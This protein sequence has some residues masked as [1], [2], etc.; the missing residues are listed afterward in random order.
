MK[1]FLFFVIGLLTL[2]W[3]FDGKYAQAEQPN[4]DCA[5]LPSVVFKTE[6]Q[7]LPIELAE[8]C[9]L[10][11]DAFAHSYLQSLYLAH[12]TNVSESNRTTLMRPDGNHSPESY[13]KALLIRMLTTDSRPAYS[14]HFY[15]QEYLR[16]AVEGDV[17]YAK[18]LAVYRNVV[19]RSSNELEVELPEDMGKAHREAIEYFADGC[20]QVRFSPERNDEFLAKYWQTPEYPQML[21]NH[22]ANNCGYAIDFAE[23]NALKPQVVGEFFITMPRLVFERSRGLEDSM[24][25]L[26]GM[27]AKEASDDLVPE[28]D[29]WLNKYKGE[30]TESPLDW[31]D[32]YVPGKKNLCYRV[33]FRDHFTCMSSLSMPSPYDVRHSSEYELCRAGEIAKFKDALL[34]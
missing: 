12:L 25:T 4:A 2:T 30:L 29:H 24:A 6:F 34:D 17:R 27:T 31:C 13:L 1:S 28:V 20:T 33:A 18:I 22:V 19:S 23:R 14:D 15:W 11:D 5:S 10:E 21:A 8:H 3:D 9:F 26:K 32:Q 7:D 16:K